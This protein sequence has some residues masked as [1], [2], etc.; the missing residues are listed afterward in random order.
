M[1]SIN[2][3]IDDGNCYASAIRFL[4]R[5]IGMGQRDAARQVRRRQRVFDNIRRQR[6]VCQAVQR[7]S[8]I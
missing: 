6:V 2:T 8:I 5:L 3:G 1:R 7:P 4:L